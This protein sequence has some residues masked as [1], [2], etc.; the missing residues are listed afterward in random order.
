MS[1][2]W[3]SGRW[4]SLPHPVRWVGAAVIGTALVVA[5]LVFMVLPGP[6]I[7]LVILGLVVLATEFAW[8]ESILHRVK[9]HAATVTSKV[10]SRLPKNSRLP[11]RERSNDNHPDAHDQAA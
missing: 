7:P 6:G 10:S 9:R 3:L 11:R 1:R 2:E 5:G 8:A 4:G